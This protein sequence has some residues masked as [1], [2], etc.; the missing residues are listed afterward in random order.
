MSSSFCRDPRILFY[1]MKI[2]TVV[3]LAIKDMQASVA[4]IFQRLPGGFWILGEV[5]FTRFEFQI[6]NR[7]LT[8]RRTGID[9]TIQ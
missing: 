8:K 5:I 7:A 6:E 9:P 2:V 4:H 3:D 1:E